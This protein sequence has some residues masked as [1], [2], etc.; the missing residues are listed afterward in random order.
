MVSH[1]VWWAGVSSRS[2]IAYGVSWIRE[3][4]RREPGDVAV[5]MFNSRSFHTDEDI[6]TEVIAAEIDDDRV[7]VDRWDGSKAPKGTKLWMLSTGAVGIKPWLRLAAKHPFRRRT[8]V[9]TDEGLG[10]YG[11][12]KSRH[13]ATLRQGGK[14]PQA[15]LRTTAVQCAT[16]LLTHIRWPLH[17]ETSPGRWGLNKPVADEFRRA[18]PEPDRSGKR[19]AFLTQPWPEGGVMSQEQYAA[20]VD[21]VARAVAAAGMEFVVV[22]HPGEPAQRYARYSAASTSVLA[23]YSPVVLGATVIVG[24]SSTAMLNVAAIHGVPAVRVGTPELTKLDQEMSDKQQ[25]LLGQY[26]AP[27]LTPAELGRRLS[28]GFGR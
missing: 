12:W 22:P 24:A 28:Q 15:A 2:H 19:V 14:D 23:E 9:V 3:M 25:S 10:T 20:H 17:V 26:A 13:A 6:S 27:S 7:S 8:V 11:N 16:G 21:E 18:A 1:D 4:L 5:H